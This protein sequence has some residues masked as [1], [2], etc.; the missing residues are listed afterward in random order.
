MLVRFFLLS[1]ISITA[2]AETTADSPTPTFESNRF[3]VSLG[4]NSYTRFYKPHVGIGLWKPN[5][6]QTYLRA[7]GTVFGGQKAINVNGG[8][9]LYE[10]NA[11]F[12]GPKLFAGFV[13]GY[14][15]FDGS[16]NE[17]SDYP[18]PAGRFSGTNKQWHLGPEVGVLFGRYVTC[19]GGMLYYDRKTSGTKEIASVPGAI[20]SYSTEHQLMLVF[21][22][23][24]GFIF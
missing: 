24:A 4:F 20:P 2:V 18:N 14:S 21:S 8:L 9:I 17:T 22:V 12:S 23:S 5:Y 7:S 11:A 16:Y 15:K 1:L 6:S 10:Q 13:A 19:T 3:E